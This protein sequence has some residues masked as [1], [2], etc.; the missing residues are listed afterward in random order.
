MRTATLLILFVATLGGLL[1]VGRRADHPGQTA[2]ATFAAGCFWGVE[3]AFRRTRGVTSTVVGY[4]G[5]RTDHPTYA[6]VSLGNTGHVEAVQV[7]FDPS[8]VS[9]AELLDVFWSCHDP[10]ID[11]ADGPH[12]SVIFFDDAEQEATAIASRA[13]VDRSGTFNRPIVTRLSPM[14]PFHPAEDDHQNYLATHGMTESCHVGPAVVHTRL[15]A[16]AAAQRN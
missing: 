1:A 9:Y 10:T 13:E 11:R 5:G 14:A 15:A 3:A 2:R 16:A 6:Q 12:A 8:Q 7:T 4:T